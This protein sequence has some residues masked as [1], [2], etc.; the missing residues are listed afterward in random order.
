MEV[1]RDNWRSIMDMATLKKTM[2]RNDRKRK[3]KLDGPGFECTFYSTIL[4]S[5][6]TVTIGRQE[7]H[8][9]CKKPGEGFLP[10][11]EN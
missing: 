6:L 7:A 3:M 9:N 8:S 4:R 11:E 5:A 1:S 10:D 2:P